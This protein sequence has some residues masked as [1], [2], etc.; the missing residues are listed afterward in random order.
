MR[1]VEGFEEIPSGKSPPSG[2]ASGMSSSPE[3]SPPSWGSYALGAI[4]VV[5]TDYFLRKSVP[6][7]PASARGMMGIAAT[8]VSPVFVQSASWF[9][10]LGHT[11]M[12]APQGQ[13][14]TSLQTAFWKPLDWQAIANTQ[15]RISASL[16]AMM[17]LG[18]IPSVAVDGL[19]KILESVGLKSAEHIQSGTFGHFLLSLG[20]SFYLFHWI[21]KSPR[22]APLLSG[23]GAGVAGIA[24]QGLRVLGGA[25]LV[26]LSANASEWT[27]YK[28]AGQSND[29]HHLIDL[30]ARDRMIYERYENILGKKVTPYVYG[31]T[32]MLGAFALTVERLVKLGFGNHS[33]DEEHERY[34]S[35]L[36]ENLE[37]FGRNTSIYVAQ[38]IVGSVGEKGEINWDRVETSLAQYYQQNSKDI[39]IAYDQ[40]EK[41]GSHPFL[42]RG[43]AVRLR[44]QVNGEGRLQVFGDS[45]QGLYQMVRKALKGEIAHLQ[46]DLVEEGLKM[47][48][49]QK[50]S[51]QSGFSENFEDQKILLKRDL[52]PD[53]R[54]YFEEVMRPLAQRQMLLEALLEKLETISG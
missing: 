10:G 12:T 49:V 44:E 5:G 23:E 25:M 33:V 35:E 15:G 39:T 31:P 27:F 22:L 8:Y 4:G 36:I 48:I 51:P 47:G 18:M 2:Q 26:N 3:P 1:Q 42:K 20:A 52:S 11:F 53:Q 13:L 24:G 40:I 41:L 6:D 46:D 43:Y 54:K 21:S 14:L 45:H 28:I 9:L 16:P 30:Q 7:M 29:P 37:S 32:N 19:G 50:E 17:V 34:Q 38:A